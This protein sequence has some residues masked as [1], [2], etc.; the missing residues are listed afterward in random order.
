MASKGYSGL[1]HLIIIAGPLGNSVYYRHDGAGN[2]VKSKDQRSYETSFSYSPNDLI[3]AVTDPL[4]SVTSYGYDKNGNRTS[5]LD[6]EA[7]DPIC[8]R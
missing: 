8:R 5:Q 4:S 7:H 1:D 3:T 2:R 6:A